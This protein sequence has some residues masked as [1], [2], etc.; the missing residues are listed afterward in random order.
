MIAMKEVASSMFR[1]MMFPHN[2]KIVKIDQ[3]THY[4]PNHS[5]NIDNILPLAH[6][7]SDFFSVI[8]IGLGIFKDPSLLGAYHG[9]SPL[10]N[11]SISSQVSIVSSNRIDI[12]D[13]THLIEAPAHIS[14][15]PVGESLPQ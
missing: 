8:D 15:P 2:G 14:I 10:L 13:N 6:T 9:A 3:I 12:R 4:E 1:M 7:S 5:T 11:P